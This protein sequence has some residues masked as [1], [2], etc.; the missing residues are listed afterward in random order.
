[1]WIFEWAFGWFPKKGADRNTGFDMLGVMPHHD[2]DARLE[3]VDVEHV[4]PT[5]DIDARLD[6]WQ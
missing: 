1:M 5:F 4:L 2:Y 3:P 6:K